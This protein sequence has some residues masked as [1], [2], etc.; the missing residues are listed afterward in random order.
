MQRNA[1]QRG[2]PRLSTTSRVLPLPLTFVTSVHDGADL[3][4]RVE[5]LRD[6]AERTRLLAEQAIDN[7]HLYRAVA[8]FNRQAD[9]YDCDC[10]HCGDDEG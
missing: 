8:E 5:E 3:S 6:R 2:P 10:G 1:V 9:A 4:C 7:D